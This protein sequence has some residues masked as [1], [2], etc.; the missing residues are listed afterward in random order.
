LQAAAR[1]WSMPSSQ[2]TPVVLALSWRDSPML[3]RRL[4]SGR[5]GKRF[6]WPVGTM[7]ALAWAAAELV[8]SRQPNMEVS[9]SMHG[10]TAWCRERRW[11]PRHGFPPPSDR[12]GLP[13]Q[14]GRQ[15]AWQ[16]FGR[17]PGSGSSAAWCIRNNSN[18]WEGEASQSGIR[19]AGR[20]PG[21]LQ[22]CQPNI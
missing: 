22:W 5:S 6:P 7:H 20:Q 10:C 18:E 14:S 19:I 2:T 21:N 16:S 13:R 1:S 9:V 3:R 17:S 12:L 4:P 11:A 8:S 15:C